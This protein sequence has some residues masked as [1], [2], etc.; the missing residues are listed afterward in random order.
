MAV[1][2]VPETA[3]PLSLAGVIAASSLVIVPVAADGD[4]IDAPLLLE[5]LVMVAVT[6]SL[7][8]PAESLVGSTSNV[9]VVDP[10]VIVNVLVA[11]VA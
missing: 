2:A 5:T 6:V 7:G 3:V 4:P 10:A 1:E 11:N 8:S 9:A